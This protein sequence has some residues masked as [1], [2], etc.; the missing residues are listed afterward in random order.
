[1]PWSACRRT[2][3]RSAAGRSTRRIAGRSSVT[4][5]GLRAA[6]LDQEDR[7]VAGDGGAP[8]SGL[9]GCLLRL[10]LLA[11]PCGL[12][13]GT[14]GHRRL[15]EPLVPVPSDP[16]AR[17]VG[18]VPVRSTRLTAPLDY[19]RD[20]VSGHRR[21]GPASVRGRSCAPGRLEAVH[22]DRL[23]DLGIKDDQLRHLEGLTQ[24]TVLES[25]RKSSDHG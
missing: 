18:S 8:G 25:D 3:A 7:L 9:R 15:E 21:G 16:R 10:G 22:S 4:P 19:L 1:M 14:T 17:P 2:A 12:A 20:R 24:L 5:A 23:R 13:G 11:V 6:S